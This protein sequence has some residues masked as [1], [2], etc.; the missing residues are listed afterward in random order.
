MH[1]IDFGFASKY[2]EPSTDDGKFK[3]AACQDLDNFRGNIIFASPHQLDF[4]STSRRDDI[5]SLC[6]L[7]VYFNS[8]GQIPGVKNLDKDYKKL[9]KEITAVKEAHTAMDI[10]TDEFNSRDLF[11][12]VQEAFSLEYDQKPDYI[13]L[14]AILR[15]LIYANDPHAHEYASKLDEKLNAKAVQKP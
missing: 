5:I 11:E 6:Y 2:T 8:K 12:F 13:K 14:R 9:Y 1:L 4:K 10:C 3:H 15:K 7:M